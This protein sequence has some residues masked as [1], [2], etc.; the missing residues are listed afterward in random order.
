[1]GKRSADVRIKR[2]ELV[3][4][5]GMRQQMKEVGKLSRQVFPPGVSSQ[6]LVLPR[7]RLWLCQSLNLCSSVSCIS[8][9]FTL[10]LRT[11]PS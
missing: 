4:V 1:M 10:E 7:V 11:S 3:M 8:R 6:A 2:P 9:L 5:E